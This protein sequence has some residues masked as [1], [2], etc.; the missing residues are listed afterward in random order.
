MRHAG[1][2]AGDSLTN[3]SES[4]PRR[5][6]R[7]PVKKKKR[8]AIGE[9]GGGGV[10]AR[11]PGTS[12]GQKGVALGSQSTETSGGDYALRDVTE[13]TGGQGR[14]GTALRRKRLSAPSGGPRA[15]AAGCGAERPR[16]NSAAPCR[17]AVELHA[18]PSR[19][20]SGRPSR[21]NCAHRVGG[22]LS[23]QPCSKTAPRDPCGRHEQR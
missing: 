8:L 21:S 14:D 4:S 7:L 5:A 13:D 23:A 6:V 9:S 22:T 2:E 19:T 16:S 11:A 12:V 15:P 18:G 10:P 3:G 1:T 20:S 17:C